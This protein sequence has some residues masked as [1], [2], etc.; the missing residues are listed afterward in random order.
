MHSHITKTN[1]HFDDGYSNLG[2]LRMNLAV[3]K[4]V[5]VVQSGAKPFGIQYKLVE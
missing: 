2:P 3:D 4:Y 1:V 5:L